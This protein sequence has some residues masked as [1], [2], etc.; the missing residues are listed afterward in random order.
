MPEIADLAD[1]R[2]ARTRAAVQ[3][4]MHDLFEEEG[5]AGLTHQRIAQRSGVGRAT[6]YRHWPR[7][8]D[9]LFEAVGVVDQPLMHAGPGPLR[10]WMVREVRRAARELAR[11]VS[12][13]MVA[14]IMGQGDTSELIGEARAVMWERSLAPVRQALA[15]AVRDGELRRSPDPGE[16]LAQLL[17][18]L[19]V[20]L[21]I[22]KKP[23]SG[24]FVERL[25]DGTL[26]SVPGY[27]PQLARRAT[28][29]TA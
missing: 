28:A 19:I 25:V 15:Q 26:A 23:V 16:V 5:T 27:R 3:R 24:P 22:E 11:P 7:P 21:A 2:V 12:L 9:L 14:A 6:I 13:Q 20:R 29:S 1:A 10:A 4:A 17:G 18:P 8:I